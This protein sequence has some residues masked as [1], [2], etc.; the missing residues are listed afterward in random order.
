MKTTDKQTP[1]QIL[2]RRKV[3]LRLKSNELGAALEEKSIYLQNNIGGLLRDAMTTAVVSQLPSGIQKLVGRK[4][5]EQQ[6]EPT[7][8][9]ATSS[10]KIMNGALSVL[11]FF[12]KGKKAVVVTLAVK[13][14]R[15]FFTS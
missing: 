10:S 14:I 11:P 4:T 2:E 9:I 13:L 7:A 12:F 3:R 1:I 8:S 15:K 5:K 6:Q